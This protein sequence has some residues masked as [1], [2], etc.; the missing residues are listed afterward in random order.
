VSCSGRYQ[1]AGAKT[2]GRT[3]FPS[4]Q[5]CCCPQMLG[6][7]QVPLSTQ[8]FTFPFVLSLLCQYVGKA[9]EVI[10]R[11]VLFSQ[12][13]KNAKSQKVLERSW[14]GRNLANQ[15]P[16][17]LFYKFRGSFSAC[18]CMDKTLMSI[19][20]LGW[21]I[22]QLHLSTTLTMDD[23]HRGQIQTPQLRH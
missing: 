20:K 15:P 8:Y 5:W 4:I 7:H 13:L 22:G 14:E 3:V 21:N 1:T 11:S 9:M 16:D 17:T 12:G 2:I 18:T 6:L 23:T 10:W 19:T